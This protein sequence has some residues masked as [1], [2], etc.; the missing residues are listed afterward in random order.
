MRFSVGRTEIC[1]T[2]GAVLFCAFGIVAGEIETLLCA[3]L[4]LLVHEAAHLIAARNLG[5][6]V[7]GITVYPFG[8]V[9]R[10]DELSHTA[11]AEWIAAAAGPLGSLTFAAFLRLAGTL[12]TDAVW[13]N[14]LIDANLAI[15]IVNL[16][17]AFPLDGGRVFRAIL[18]RTVRERT[19]RTVLLSF[20]ALAALGMIGAGIFLVQHGVPAWTLFAIPPFLIASAYREWH[21]PD[22]GVVSRVMERKAVLR[23]G[24]AEK[25]QIVVLNDSA[26]I[27][28]AVLS[29][30]G[31][32]YTLL[33]VLHANGYTELD[34]TDVLHAAAKYGTDAM[35]RNAIYR[36]TDGK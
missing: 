13:L 8:M 25:A 35:L 30:S 27:G 29:L 16:L 6:P 18:R 31:T 1:V 36:L 20:T 2:I 7:S 19:A 34:E 3:V 15:A 17:P 14:T 5:I 23:S 24:G 32:R 28:T 9:M 11:R 4:S 12:L 21:L 26:S 22:A 33:R 10:L